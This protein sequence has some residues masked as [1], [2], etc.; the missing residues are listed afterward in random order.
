MVDIWDIYEIF[1]FEIPYIEITLKE[2]V[3]A[4]LITLVMYYL[5]VKIALRYMVR[6][7]ERMRMP[8][9]LTGLIAR[10]TRVLLVIV[11]VMI[12]L[13]AIKIDVGSMVLALSAVI[14]LV[15]GFGMSD[16]MNNLFSGIW[17]AMIRPIRMDE[18][19]MIGD[20][21]GK[22]RAV[23]IMATELLTPD[24]VYITIPNKLV[25]GSAI[26]NYSRMPTRR[27][28]LDVGIGYSSSVDKAVE[29]AMRLMK[30]HP[31]VLETP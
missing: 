27:I 4:I 7:L 30:E 16:S 28:N 15:I 31:A 3:V 12:F 25:W 9:L 5:L 10:M 26:T 8:P 1:D 11:V 22:V 29:I 17:I 14:G 6:A 19:V 2:L 24:N 13:A 20:K 23:G 18:V 21:T